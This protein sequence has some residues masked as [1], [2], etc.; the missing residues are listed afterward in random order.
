M[1]CFGIHFQYVG[2][3]CERLFFPRYDQKAGKRLSPIE[4]AILLRRARPSID[5]V[6]LSRTD[7]T[8]I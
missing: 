4:D 5:A 1:F 6:T 8:R 3:I 7:G 2:Y